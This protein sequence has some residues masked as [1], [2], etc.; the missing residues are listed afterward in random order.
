MPIERQSW[1][2]VASWDGL[3]AIMR[4]AFEVFTTSDRADVQA[5]SATSTLA[6]T[7]PM[8]L[9]KVSTSG[10]NVTLT[11][12]APSTV[13]GFRLE[14][15]KLD[16]ANTVTL[17]SSANIDGATTLAFSTQYQSYRLVS[18]GVTWHI[19]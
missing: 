4:R 10:G 1:R 16:A 13:I 9:V 15:K 8:T 7:W 12:P 17:S 11:L 18:D 3:T 2:P 6:L 19:V 14:V 5:V